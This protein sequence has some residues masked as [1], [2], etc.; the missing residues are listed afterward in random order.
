MATVRTSASG[1]EGGSTAPSSSGSATERRHKGGDGPDGEGSDDCGEYCCH[2]PSMTLLA[3]ER[4]HLPCLRYAIKHRFLIHAE[5]CTA[6]ARGNFV[7]CLRLLREHNA[8]W[9]ADT[10]YAAALYGQFEAL[11][12]VME[13]GCPYDDDLLLSAAKG[14]NVMCVQYLVEERMHLM[15]LAVFGAAFEHAHAECVS[16]LLDAGCPFQDYVFSDETE[17]YIYRGYHIEPDIDERFLKCILLSVGRGW[18]NNGS[19]VCPHL[20]GYV[21][22]NSDTF[23]LC[24]A[25]I[26]NEGW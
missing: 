20:V 22:N 4:G 1:K 26:I 10:P 24:R 19:A 2:G 5:A 18:G 14:G 17:W 13:N 7:A 15:D 3:A 23:P 12:F 21:L 9:S 6:A 11:S 25:H 16:Y 8:P